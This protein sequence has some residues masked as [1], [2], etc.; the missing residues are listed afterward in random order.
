MKDVSFGVNL[1]V[2]FI[3]SLVSFAAVVQAIRLAFRIEKAIVQFTILIPFLWIFT[4]IDK[5]YSYIDFYNQTPSFLFML[6]INIM[7]AII[8]GFFFMFYKNKKT[9]AFF[10]ATPIVPPVIP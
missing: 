4:G 1:T 5:Y 2:S 8:W 9:R 10:S 6:I 7:Y 3:Y